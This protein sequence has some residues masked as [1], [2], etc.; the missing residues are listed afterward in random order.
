MPEIETILLDRNDIPSA[1][2]G[3]ALI[4]AVAPAIGTR[5]PMPTE[6]IRQYLTGKHTVGIYPLLPDETCWFLVVDF[7]KKSWMADSTAFL[8]TCRRFCIPATV[9]RSRSGNGA[10]VWM[11][12]T[13][14]LLTL[15]NCID[16]EEKL[17]DRI[18]LQ[19]VTRCSQTKS[20]F[21]HLS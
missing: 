18:K 10:H 15:Q 1:G 2:A 5:F 21:H 8:Q 14:K 7:D 4:M 19:Q 3:E 9:E 20:F 12:A 11:A 17:A 16:S 6:V 13:N